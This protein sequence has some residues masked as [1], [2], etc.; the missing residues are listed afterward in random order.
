MMEVL[1]AIGLFIIIVIPI[2]LAYSNI[3]IALNKDQARQSAITL[4]QN[5]F[6]I[7]RNMP[8]SNIGISSGYP[9]GALLANRNISYQNNN[10]NL[11]TTVR[12]IDDPYDG[13]AGGSPNDTAP[14][15]YKLVEITANCISC[16]TFTPLTMTT[17]IA[18]ISLETT[19]NN[20]SLFINVFDAD[21][22]AVPQ[23]NVHVYNGSTSPVI[24]IDDVTNNDGVLQLVDI[25]T[26]TSAYEISVSKSGYSSEQTYLMAA[27]SNPNP[28]KPHATVASQQVTQ[29]SFSIDETSSLILNTTD[30]FC[31]AIPSISFDIS[32]AK[33][34]GAS[35]D[36]LKF[37]DSTETDALGQ[38]TFGA[39]EW[40][41]Y[42]FNMTSAQYD[43]SGISQS[44][45]LIVN[46]GTNYQMNWR[47]SP[48]NP[49]A[50]LI[51]VVNGAGA[52][53]N[54]AKIT[55]SKTGFSQTFYTK[56]RDFK[57]TSWSGSSYSSQSGNI[58]TETSPGS[59]TLQQTLG[60]YPTST[61][62]LISKTID[63]G[64]SDTI[65][66]NLSWNP[67]SQ[68]GQ[69]G[70]ESLK[71][72]IASNNDNSTW[73]FIG[74]DGTAD[75]YYTSSTIQINSSHNNNRY[76]RYKVY[77]KT[78]DENFTPRIDDL[79]INFYSG[80]TISG[81]AFIN[82]LANDTYNLTIE[83]TSYQTFTDSSLIISGSWQEYKATLLP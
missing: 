25:P 45:P 60:V 76:L 35:P 48:K 83:K 46:P 75:S 28:T 13:V 16:Q 64:V 79:T 11:I 32:G 22:I 19:T 37:S 62:W 53:I 3:L 4:I 58:D 68:P 69:T 17:T 15:D 30:E 10:F 50:L 57:E 38:K 42:S 44:L 40:D 6:E 26:S 49:S 24:I 20:G 55:L 27:P 5:Q 36:I 14:A 1:V 39:L 59:F 74:P 56:R 61:E 31:K 18:P 12:N 7:A 71:I 81:Q 43:F 2:Y 72:Q 21:G 70:P 78:D 47:L 63:F 66:Y 77:M 34:I 8:Y 9:S 80:C 82:G 52:A 54:D 41:T 65:F 67:D 33:L 73:N 23:A 51:K 29:I